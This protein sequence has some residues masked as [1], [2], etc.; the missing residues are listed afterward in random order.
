MLLLIIFLNKGTNERTA[1]VLQHL[2]SL[3]SLKIMAYVKVAL[4]LSLGE[5]EVRKVWRFDKEDIYSYTLEGVEKEML[6]LYPMTKEKASMGL[7]IAY[8]DS[9]IGRVDVQSSADLH[10]SFIGMHD[11]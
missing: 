4:V 10:V 8:N 5:S 2:N 1:A 11:A 9:F 3:H 6:E 7:S